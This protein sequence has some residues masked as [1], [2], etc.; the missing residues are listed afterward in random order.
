MTL[1]LVDKARVEILLDEPLVDRLLELLSKH[2][3]HGYTIFPSSRG[4]GTS[5]A[6]Q[7]DQI[8]RAQQKVL[9]LAIVDPQKASNLATDLEPLLDPY[10]MILML[11]QVQVLRGKKY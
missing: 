11:S 7:D 1:N 8:T 9:L 4:Q 10:G 3:I 5:G 2:Q 6:W